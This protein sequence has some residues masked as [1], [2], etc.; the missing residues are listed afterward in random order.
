[1][2]VPWVCPAAP[3]RR[4]R[5]TVP[6]LLRL[7]RVTAP[8]THP[9]DALAIFHLSLRAEQAAGCPERRRPEPPSHERTTAARRA[10]L[11]A[12][13]ARHSRDRGAA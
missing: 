2:G 3:T 4:T 11:E 9:D 7:A 12:D 6:A 10:A 8:D 1:M 5:R 13:I